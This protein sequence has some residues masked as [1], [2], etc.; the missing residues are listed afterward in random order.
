ML[1]RVVVQKARCRWRNELFWLACILASLLRGVNDRIRG[2]KCKFYEERI[3]V[4]NTGT[5]VSGFWQTITPQHH[6]LRF[7]SD[8]TPHRHLNGEYLKKC[9]IPPFSIAGI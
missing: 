1:P 5:S 4:C 9:L 3:Y 7:R 2:K 8:T 6:L